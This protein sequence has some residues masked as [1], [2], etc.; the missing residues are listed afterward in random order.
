MKVTIS[1]I[2]KELNI[3]PATVS[4][5]LSN[6]PKISEKTKRP[7]FKVAFRLDPIYIFR[8]TSRRIKK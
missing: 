3:T 8:E 2:A 1:N 5:A 4:K 6:H 7:V